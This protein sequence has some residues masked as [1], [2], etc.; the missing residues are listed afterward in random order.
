MK[1]Q[2]LFCVHV[3]DGAKTF[4]NEKN[5]G[6]KPFFEEKIDG[7]STFFEEKNDGAKAFFHEKNE[8]AKTFFEAKKFLLPSICSRNFCSLPYRSVFFY[9]VSCT[10]L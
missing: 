2:G 9:T 3:D 7:A 6:A 4:F 8:G 5:D 10:I 1:G